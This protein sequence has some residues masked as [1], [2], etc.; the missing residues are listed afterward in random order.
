MPMKL[1]I[2]SGSLRGRIVQCP[3]RRLVFRP[4]LE[5]TRQAVADMLQTRIDGSVAA[6]LCA[7]SGAFGFEMI[8]RGAAR[9]DF[10]ENDRR[11]A[12]LL[13]KHAEKFGVFGQCRI[14]VRDVAD[15]VRSSGQRYDIIFFDPPYEGDGMRALIPSILSLLSGGGILLFQRRRRLRTAGNDVQSWEVPFKTMAFGGTI[16]ECYRT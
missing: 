12:A 8:S 6:D 1:R 2:V 14:V 13:G 16:V 9:V 4:T 5:R 11:C 7:G 10:V 15:F 3:E